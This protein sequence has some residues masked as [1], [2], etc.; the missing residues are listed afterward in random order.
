VSREEE[1]KRKESSNTKLGPSFPPS[2]PQY[3]FSL[4]S[5]PFQFTA[6]LKP[7]TDSFY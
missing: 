2:F 7:T 5:S 1:E 6:N 3:P 4:L